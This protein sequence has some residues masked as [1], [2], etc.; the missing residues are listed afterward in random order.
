MPFK[1][2]QSQNLILQFLFS[3]A[4][5]AAIGA[6]NAGSQYVLQGGKINIG[7]LVSISLAAFAFAFGN[8]LKVYIPSHIKDV[9]QAKD[10]TIAQLKAQLATQQQTLPAPVLQQAPTQP[11][12]V[13]ITPTTPMQATVQLHQ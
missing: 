1:P 8:A 2:T 9:L 3:T 10:D 11:V 12:V 13:N 6:I 7:V 5:S 4:I